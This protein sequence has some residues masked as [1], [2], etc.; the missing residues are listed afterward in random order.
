[1]APFEQEL[2]VAIK[3]VAGGAYSSYAN[4]ELKPGDVVDVMAPSGKFSPRQEEVEGGND[5]ARAAGSGITPV[6]SSIKQT[7]YKHPSHRFTLIYGNRNRQSIIFFDEL[8][9]LKNKFIGR[10]QFI[11]VLSREKTDVPLNYGRINAEKLQA[12]QPIVNFSS[13][14][15][16][17]I[18]GPEE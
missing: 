6:I 11:H 8:E 7:L 2:K 10:F 12:L 16:I 1:S 4:L 9:A 15:D 5:L 13:F 3:K 18:C 14:N 17:F